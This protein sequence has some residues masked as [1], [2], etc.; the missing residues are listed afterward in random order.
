MY[1]SIPAF[2]GERG[3]GFAPIQHQRVAATHFS[4]VALSVLPFFLTRLLFPRWPEAEISLD[5]RIQGVTECRFEKL[6]FGG[7]S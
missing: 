1:R 6:N 2:S 5:G 4:S 3:M 7:A